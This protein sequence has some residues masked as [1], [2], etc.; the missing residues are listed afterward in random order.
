MSRGLAGL[1]LALAAAVALLAGTFR[2]ALPGRADFAFSNGSEPKTLDPQLMTGEPEGRIAESLFEGLTR[3]EAKSLEPAPGAAESWDVTPDG[4][5]YTFHIRA[6][7]RWS[8]GHPVTAHDFTYSWRR[9]QDPSVAAEYAYIMHMVRYAEAY[10]THQEQAQALQGPL[11]KAF[12][13]LLAANPSVVPKQALQEFEAPGTDAER[14]QNLVSAIESVARRLG[15]TATV[16]RKCYV[17]PFVIDAYMNG[18]LL[19]VLQ[20][21]VDLHELNP[22]EATVL[23]LLQ[24]RL[25]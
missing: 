15:N 6:D 22:E 23:A 19:E 8:D 16:C 20:Q 13:E 24:Q 10:N 9:L 4:K 11:L 14:R 25:D 21:P 7:A 3:L 17:H 1:G 12:D 18:S 5:T 2:A